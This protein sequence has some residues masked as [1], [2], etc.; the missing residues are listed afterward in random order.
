MVWIVFEF[1]AAAVSFDFVSCRGGGDGRYGVDWAIRLSS[2]WE[3]GS[4]VRGWG[5]GMRFVVWRLSF[6]DVCWCLSV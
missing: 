3:T 2:C 1:V 5:E 6:Q 4:V